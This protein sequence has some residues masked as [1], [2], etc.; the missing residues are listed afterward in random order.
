MIIKRET[1]KKFLYIVLFFILANSVAFSK[2]PYS[3]SKLNLV[4]DGMR[5]PAIITT[6][7]F[8]SP[9]ANILLIPG[10]LASDVDGNYPAMNLYPHMYADLSRQLAARGYRVIRYAKTGE[11]SGSEIL[12]KEIAKNYNH[13]FE[14]ITV[15]K[16][17]LNHLLKKSDN[18]I[19]TFIAGHSE[20]SFVAFLVAQNSN[21]KINGIISLSGPAYRYFDLMFE[22]AKK[23]KDKDSEQVLKRLEKDIAII[24][25]GGKMPTEIF[26]D[27]YL[28]SLSQLNDDEW[29]YLRETDEIDPSKEI[30]KINLPVL[31]IQGGSDDI[32]FPE[33]VIKLQDSRHSLL[34]KLVYFKNLQHFYKE[35]KPG[36][37]AIASSSSSE[38]SNPIVAEAIDNW[39][40]HFTNIY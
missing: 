16:V 4:V 27:P 24:R 10:T 30:A 36:M 17:A 12:D 34:T 21:V 29:Q 28:S 35:V 19:P 8:K 15:A 31:L 18:M 26:S 1:M 5:I 6:P 2:T 22:F 20:G 23:Q 14:R 7:N 9:S 32:I 38:E 3:E 33:N 37:N 40:M 11:G 13:F 39:I 25:I